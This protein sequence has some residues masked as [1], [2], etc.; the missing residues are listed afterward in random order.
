MNKRL[1]LA[2]AVFL[3]S[4]LLAGS[5]LLFSP[6]S[7]RVAPLPEI[8][9][10]WDIEDTHVFSEMPLL[11]TLLWEG[12]PLP[13]YAE[14]ASFFC[15]L[16]LGRGEAWPDLD[17]KT[18]EGSDVSVCFADD[19]LY[20]ACEDAVRDGTPYR[21]LVW[22]QEKY[23]YQNIVFTGLPVLSLHTDADEIGREDVACSAVYSAPGGALQSSARIH[24]RGASSLLTVNPKHGFRLEFTRTADG[25][26][27]AAR[28]LPDF[29]RADTLV[30]LPL[31][32][33]ESLIRDRLGWELWNRL[34]SPEEPFGPRRLTYCELFLNDDYRGIYLAMEPFKISEE[35]SRAGGSHILQDSVY[36]TAALNFSH[37]RAYYTHPVRLNAGYELYYS[38]PGF[39]E[40]AALQPY[41]RLVTEP[42]D[43]AF[44]QAFES[45]I[46]MDSVLR[47][48]LFVQAGGMT[49]NVFNNMYI[50]A[51]HASGKTV[52]HFSP[53]DLD[54]TWGLKKEDIGEE[55]ENWLYF[56]VFDRALNLDV[57]SLRRRF[58]GL[59]EDLKS[60]VLSFESVE[61]VT[62]LCTR[63]LNESGAMMRNAER[64][65][66]EIYE[67]GN[68]EILDFYSR[69]LLLMD[70]AVRQFTDTAGEIPFL[71]SSEYNGR[72]G[73]AIVYYGD[74]MTS[75]EL[76]ALAAQLKA[77][78]E[79]ETQ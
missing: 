43:T 13:W 37:D 57:C 49:D 76:E 71:S 52:Y 21:L 46:D 48:V 39:S 2:S 50:W 51:D 30:L 16:G 54:M 44:A 25:R 15:P 73:G 72:R 34:S 58:A 7:G 8:E 75:E 27:K 19:Y 69:R 17:L 9:A 70:E 74:Y 61:S 56:P 59:W 26:K 10:V 22:T 35:L 65:Q 11:D 66:T 4:L 42:D 60:G 6:V 36:R 18:P 32:F 3:L 5:V 79:V 53:W 14:S 12:A 68:Q 38:P 78:E 1:F 23:C 45:C 62:E 55:F 67:S 47:Y 64:W 29:G 63:E 31:I 41:I 20:D 33:D 40:F 77:E 24:R 28:D